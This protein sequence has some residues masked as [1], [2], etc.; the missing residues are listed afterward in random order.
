MRKAVTAECGVRG[1]ERTCA[2]KRRADAD[3]ARERHLSAAAR[4]ATRHSSIRLQ[5]CFR[6]ILLDSIFDRLISRHREEEST[7]Y[8]SQL[9]SSAGGA[10]DFA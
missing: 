5:F 3:L 4:F 10:R 9:C 2:T 7:N 6:K 8:E 1:A